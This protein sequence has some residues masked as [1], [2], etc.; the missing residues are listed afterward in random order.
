MP[1]LRWQS[2]KKQHPDAASGRSSR[3][4]GHKPELECNRPTQSSAQAAQPTTS[5]HCTHTTATISLHPTL[6]RLDQLSLALVGWPHCSSEHTDI[7]TVLLYCRRLSSIPHSTL[8]LTQPRPPSPSWAVKPIQ[9]T[10]IL[11]RPAMSSPP[12]LPLSL[13]LRPSLPLPQLLL[14]PLPPIWPA[15]PS[16]RR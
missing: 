4:C 8:T 2:W 13:V 7:H 9:P 15:S 11:L 6:Q 10:P 12:R 5:P 14:L 3:S 16:R 1:S